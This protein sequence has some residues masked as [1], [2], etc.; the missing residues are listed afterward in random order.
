MWKVSLHE[1]ARLT[2][3]CHTH[4]Q[5]AFF[6]VIEDF[7]LLR[8]N[9]ELH[10]FIPFLSSVITFSIV[11][12]VN[13]LLIVICGKYLFKGELIFLTVAL[14]AHFLKISLLG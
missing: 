6:L 12:N 14:K 1:K 8:A 9:F 4:Y 11:I 10:Q 13:L 2:N 3:Q 7:Q 5:I